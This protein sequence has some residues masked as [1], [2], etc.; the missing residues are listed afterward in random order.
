MGNCDTQQ[1][2]CEASGK[3]FEELSDERG[4]RGSW[5]AY[6]SCLDE[7]LAC[8]DGVVNDSACDAELSAFESDCDVEAS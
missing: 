8:E 4:C 3:A 6:V 1:S 2:Q 5:D 7:S